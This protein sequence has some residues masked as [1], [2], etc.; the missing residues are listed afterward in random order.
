MVVWR[1]KQDTMF[2]TQTSTARRKAKAQVL[3]AR[4]LLGTNQ[5]CAST[6]YFHLN[7]VRSKTVLYGRRKNLFQ[8][9]LVR[10][11]VF[12]HLAGKKEVLGS[13]PGQSCV[14][15]FYIPCLFEC[16]SS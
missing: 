6:P 2:A 10:S 16:I 11:T 3:R 9:V 1:R 8:T 4:L 13:I 14:F 12:Y 7:T 15:C 5:L